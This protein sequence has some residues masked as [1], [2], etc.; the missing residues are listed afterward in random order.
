MKQVKG[1]TKEGREAKEHQRRAEQHG[2]DGYCYTA[3]SMCPAVE[4][5]PETRQREFIATL[6]A[7]AVLLAVPLAGLGL[8]IWF[9]CSLL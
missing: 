9:I 8:V 4:V 2:C 6:M 3:K 5:C 7:L 1:Y